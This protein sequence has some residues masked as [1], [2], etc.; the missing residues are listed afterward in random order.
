MRLAAP[1]LNS[2]SNVRVCRFQYPA[3]AGIS[4]NQ[5]NVQP[6]DRVAESLDSQN[7][8]ITDASSCPTVNGLATTLHQTCANSN[9]DRANDCPAN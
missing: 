7:Y 3:A 8:L 6:Y 1:G 2:G 9:Q 5:R 4:A